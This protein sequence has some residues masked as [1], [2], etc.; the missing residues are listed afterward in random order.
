M[1]ESRGVR[2][3]SFRRHAGRQ[4][5][6]H[7]AGVAGA[8]RRELRELTGLSRT[9]VDNVLAG[10]LTEGLIEEMAPVNSLVVGRPARVLRL[11][12]PRRTTLVIQPQARRIRVALVDVRGFV[13]AGT[14]ID[15]LI[16]EGRENTLAKA[17]SALP[18][19]EQVA[20]ISPDRVVLV[21]PTMVD[22]QN[23]EV[24]RDGSR[25]RM[26]TWS[27]GQ[28]ADRVRSI[29]GLP[30][31]LEN[32]A[33]AATLAEHRIGA[34]AGF[35]S[36]IY[37]SIGANG[38]GGG[39]IMD[40]KIVRGA[41]GFAGEISHV[42][43]SPT[44]TICPCGQRGC[45]AAEVRAQILQFRGLVGTNP[46]LLDERLPL[47]ATDDPARRR[48]VMDI[49]SETARAVGSLVNVFNPQAVIIAEPL[50]ENLELSVFSSFVEGLT[51]YVHPGILRGLSLRPSSLGPD[52]SI[53][54]AGLVY[55]PWGS[56]T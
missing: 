15:C 10:L 8:S 12:R 13:L 52:A 54:G 34:A 41:S 51:R 27:D 2:V 29:F 53:K 35:L 20:G 19:L 44:G 11:A 47:G 50:T 6:E 40:G 1:S 5:L 45:L 36:A 55:P 33:K 22:F 9:A 4:I 14:D 26:P 16:E 21:L 43:V 37:V 48:L 23:Q 31:L 3:A 25:E 46:I 28:T 24:D 18:E 32:G 30:V 17:L 38:I 56:E 7:L 39:L 42:S 49:G